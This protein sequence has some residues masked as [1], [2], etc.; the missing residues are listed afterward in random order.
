MAAPVT[1]NEARA[2]RVEDIFDVTDSPPADVLDSLN[3]Y[4]GAFA[5]PVRR[6][7][8]QHCLSCDARLG[9]V[10]AALGFGAAY[11]WGLAHGEATCTGCGWPAR[12]MHR[13]KGADGTEILSL[14]NFFLAYHPDQVVRR[15]DASAEEDA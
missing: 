9:G 5:A 13:V 15:E 12:G 1:K 7:G 2:C 10:A 3:A 14:S 6:D 4:F 8:A 11:Q